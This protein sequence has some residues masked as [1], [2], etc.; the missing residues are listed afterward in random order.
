MVKYFI[1]PIFYGLRTAKNECMKSHGKRLLM[2]TKNAAAVALGRKG[3]K[4]RAEKLTPEQRSESA[5]KAVEARWAK[6]RA[7]T[8]DIDE[9]SK[10]LLKAVQASARKA[11]KKAKLPS[12]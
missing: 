8:K 4:A 10:K 6:L 5:R 11:R 12:A 1:Y 3:G 2:T 9:R 7:L